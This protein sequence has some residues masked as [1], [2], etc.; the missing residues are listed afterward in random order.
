[1]KNETAIHRHGSE[2]IVTPREATGCPVCD[3]S[4]RI[5]QWTEARS[6]HEHNAPYR[7]KERGGHEESDGRE[8]EAGESP[9]SVSGI[10]RPQ[11]PAVRAFSGDSGVFRFAYLIFRIVSYCKK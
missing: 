9:Y 2:S 3:L 5:G 6:G 8:D 7:D 11:T 1:M 10:G 4:Q